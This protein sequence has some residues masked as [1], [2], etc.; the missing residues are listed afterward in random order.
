MLRP[1]LLAFCA[2][3]AVSATAGHAADTRE[4]HTWWG[5][6]ELPRQWRPNEPESDAVKVP[7]EI[8][9]DENVEPVSLKQAIAIAL[10]NNPRIAAQR[11][12][13]AKQEAGILGAQAQFD[14]TLA[15]EVRQAHS[16]TPN[17]SVLAATDT[18]V[19]DERS[20]NAHLIKRLRTSTLLQGDFLNERIDNNASFNQLRPAYQPALNFSV[21]QPLLRDFGWDFSYLVVRV[22]EQTA[23]A[24]RF[25]YEADLAN[26]VAEVIVAYWAVVQTRENLEV[27]RESLAL[28]ER[29]VSEN[30]ARVRVGL[31]APVAVLEARADAK[32]RE[33][34]VIIAENDLVVA[35]QR[36]GQ[37]AYYRPDDTFVPRTLEP[38]EE[39]EPEQVDVNLDATISNAV[40]ERPEVRASAR[41]VQVTVLNERIAGNALLPRVDLVGSYGLNGLSGLSRPVITNR[42]VAGGGCV[43]IGADPPTFSCNSP[44]A[45][46]VGDAYDRMTTNEFRSYTFGVQVQVPIANAAAR[47]DYTQSRITRSQAE[48]NHRALLSQITFDARASVADVVSTRQRIDTS[49]V[50]RE[51]AEENLRNQEKRHEVGL[52]TTKDLLDFQTR[53]TSAR[54]AEVQAKTDY[55]ISVARWRRAQGRLLGHYQ[56]VLD[57][58]GH[59]TTPWFARF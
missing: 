2:L 1:P 35:R 27:Q 34:D 20:A 55:A 37:L 54:A 8:T 57:E 21:I 44:Y 56:I 42:N 5:A 41:G 29:T 47:S 43:Q 14:P 30:E 50:A 13:P 28:A 3:V 26:F 58:A 19:I 51:L 45:G 10:E 32:A 15:A 38:T 9:Q 49:R 39:A 46:P 16:R 31:L 23:D 52:A 12:E 18:L 6:R 22:A 7:S 48:L 4:P 53:L 59:R 33:E 36:L 11:L 40:N 17:Q 24:A 25:Q